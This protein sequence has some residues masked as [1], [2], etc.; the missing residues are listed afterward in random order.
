[1]T[2]HSRANRWWKSPSTV[3]VL[4]PDIEDRQT[5]VAVHQNNLIGRVG[6]LDQPEEPP[7]LRRE[8]VETV[9]RERHAVGAGAEDTGD[10]AFENIRCGGRRSLPQ[11]PSCCGD[12]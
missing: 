1:M 11:G 5:S 8:E 3:E 4:R 9:V 12:A 10:R 7:L 6:F 2:G